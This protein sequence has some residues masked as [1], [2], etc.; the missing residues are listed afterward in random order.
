MVSLFSS[1]ETR[2]YYSTIYPER[3]GLS[4]N[5]LRICSVTGAVTTTWCRV[6]NTQT[7][8]S[9]SRL[10]WDRSSR[11]SDWESPSHGVTPFLQTLWTSGGLAPGLQQLVCWQGG[12]G[13]GRK[14]PTPTPTST[15]SKAISPRMGPSLLPPSCRAVAKPGLY[16][17]PDELCSR[18]SVPLPPWCQYRGSGFSQKRV[19]IL[20]A[21]LL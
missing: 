6:I 21:A 2:S 20:P 3:S 13:S 11:E 18:N 1:P 12:P 19:P 16:P 17:G 4:Q 9:S 8:T 7:A 5:R 15:W 14:P 10:P